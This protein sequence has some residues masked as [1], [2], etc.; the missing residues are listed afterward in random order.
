VGEGKRMR[1]L[2]VFAKKPKP[3]T[4]VLYLTIVAGLLFYL[5]V[6]RPQQQ[7]Y[8]V[9]YVKIQGA[10]L[11]KPAE[12]NPFE[13]TDI[14]GKPFTQESLKGHWS[15]IYFGFTQCEVICP[16]VMAMLNKTYAK[17]LTTL[18]SGDMPQI[19]FVTIDPERDSLKKISDFIVPFNSQFIGVRGSET[20]TLALE[21][22]LHILATKSQQKAKD[23]SLNHTSDI[24]LINPK[25]KIQ[26]YFTYPQNVDALVKDY[27]L[28]LTQMRRDSKN[29]KGTTILN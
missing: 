16:T 3:S 20:A 14:H 6:L 4:I 28:I 17:L 8:A 5:F 12:I 24:L 18:P 15:M 11:L 13:L 29:S 7:F 23:Y 22:E 1:Q 9:H 21:K 2:T 26:A 10:Y 25:G 27:Q 19:I